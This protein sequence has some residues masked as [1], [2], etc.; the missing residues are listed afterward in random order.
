[1][2]V[3]KTHPNISGPLEFLRVSV[4]AKGNDPGISEVRLPS[5]EVRSVDTSWLKDLPAPKAP[6]PPPPAPA[7]IPDAKSS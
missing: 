5:G 3:F 6:I 2:K 1:M 4:P 7:P